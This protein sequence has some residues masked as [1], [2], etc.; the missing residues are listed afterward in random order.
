MFFFEH[1]FFSFFRLGVDV[2]SLAELHLPSLDNSFNLMFKNRPQFTPL[3]PALFFLEAFASQD[4]LVNFFFY[5]LTTSNPRG[6]CLGLVLSLVATFC[7]A[8]LDAMV[9][10][11]VLPGVAP[12]VPVPSA[13]GCP[14]F[15]F[16]SLPASSFPRTPTNLASNFFATP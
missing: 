15:V 6:G 2:F 10:V 7:F 9:D 16:T 4:A 1:P 14:F 11:P 3:L 12:S 8:P 5:R 13:L